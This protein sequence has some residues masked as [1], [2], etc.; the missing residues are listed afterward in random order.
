VEVL[1]SAIHVFNTRGIDAALPFFRDDVVWYPTSQWIEESA[2]RGHDGLRELSTAFSQN[3]DGLGYEVH[4]IR[5]ANGRVVACVEM[6]ARIRNSGQPISQP[7]GLVV[8]GFH[9]GTFGEIRVFPS[10]AEA[11]NAVGLEE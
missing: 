11:L 7:L 8:S 4:D 1:R 9:D 6:A 5:E 10:W 2:Y 3:F